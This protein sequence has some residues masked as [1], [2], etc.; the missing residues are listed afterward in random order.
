MMFRG[1]GLRIRKAIFLPYGWGFAQNRFRRSLEA[2]RFDPAAFDRPLGARDYWASFALSR[3]RQSG[4][5]LYYLTKRD[6]E[7]SRRA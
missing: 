2:G 7:R 4:S 5:A 1:A 3:L 6:P